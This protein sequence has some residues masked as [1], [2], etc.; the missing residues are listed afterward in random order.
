MRE[1]CW[2]NAKPPCRP[3]ATCSPSTVNQGDTVIS[4]P[5]QEARLGNAIPLME[6]PLGMAVHCIELKIGKGGQMART[7]GASAGSRRRKD[8]RHWSG[9]D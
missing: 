3:H 9:W 1:R 4:G 6:V 8:T 7:A 2:Q 5:G